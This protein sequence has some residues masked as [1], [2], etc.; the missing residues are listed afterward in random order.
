[1]GVERRSAC[2]TSL[3][4]LVPRDAVIVGIDLADDKQAVVISDHDARVLDRR[5]I[6]GS[7]WQAIAGL[8]W[9]QRVA[10]DG[11]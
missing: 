8:P 3:R 7:V 11:G 5:M 6:R 2:L 10:R 9:A 1:M 4:R